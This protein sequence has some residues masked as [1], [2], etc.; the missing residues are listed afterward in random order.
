MQE[1][2]NARMHQG[3]IGLPSVRS[4]RPSFCI[5]ALVHWCILL[6]WCIRAFVHSRPSSERPCPDHS[7]PPEGNQARILRMKQRLSHRIVLVAALLC[8][9]AGAL[10]TSAERSSVAMASTAAKFVGSLTPEQR[11]QA[12]FA[13]ASDERT[14]WHFIPTDM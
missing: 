12:A 11:Q 9:F 8:V 4:L 5:R 3:N 10:L 1:C 7:L 13:F 6:H 14:H 2:T